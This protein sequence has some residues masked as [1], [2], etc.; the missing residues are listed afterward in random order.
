MLHATAITRFARALG[1]ARTGNLQAA[2]AEI[3]ELAKISAAL[4]EAKDGY[5]PAIV[6]IQA[7]TATAWTQLAEGKKDEALQTMSAAADAEDK[8]EKAPITPGPLAPARELL[9]DMLLERGMAKEALQAFEQTLAKEPNRY[10]AF[11]G[12]AAAAVA[13][14]DDTKATTYYRKLANLATQAVAAGLAVE[15][16]E[17]IVAQKY[18]AGK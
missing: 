1:A 8:T 12:A 6:D 13:S 9:G 15:R 10:R 14:A 2:K 17:L 4:R 18:T 3:A 7:Q 5:W 16:P 11:A